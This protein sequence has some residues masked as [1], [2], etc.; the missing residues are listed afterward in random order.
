[1]LPSPSPR[2]LRVD[3]RSPLRHRGTLLLAPLA[4]LVKKNHEPN[5]FV[6]PVVLRDEAAGSTL[7]AVACQAPAPTA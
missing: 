5:R 6:P 2:Q 1:M 7:R 4:G 3:P